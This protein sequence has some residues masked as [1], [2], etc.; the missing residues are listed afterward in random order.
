M[1]ETEAYIV[2][3]PER[4]GTSLAMGVLAAMG[5][6]IGDDY[7]TR[8]PFNPCYYEDNGLHQLLK[9]GQGSAAEIVNRLGVQPKWGMK[10]PRLS[11]S[12]TDLFGPLVKTPKFV[13]TH[14]ETEAAV[15][16]F[17]HSCGPER[18]L[19]EIRRHQLSHY[20]AIDK[21][22]TDRIDV[23][24]EKWFSGEGQLVELAH[25][26]GVTVTP[27]AK[28]LVNPRERHYE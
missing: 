14:R 9:F 27:E 28:A 20:D 4:T 19:D 23:Y 25:F 8:G 5:V 26:A 6:Y 15:Q 22:A 3:G 12:W 17:K 11:F 16:S 18:S 10:L 1:D 7:K 2:V 21:F 24:F 13:V